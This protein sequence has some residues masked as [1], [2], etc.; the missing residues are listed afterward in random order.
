MPKK[1][2]AFFI[3][4]AVLAVSSFYLLGIT[5]D[6]NPQS[7]DLVNKPVPFLDLPLLEPGEQTRVT[8]EDLKGRCVMV[9]FFASWCRYCRQ[10]HPVLVRLADIPSVTLIGVNVDDDRDSVMAWL[11]KEGNPY[12][13]IGF[14][15]TDRVQ[16]DWKVSATPQTFLIDKK[17]VVLYQK[18]G[19]LSQKEVEE[20]I[21]TVF[22]S[23]LCQN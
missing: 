18:K 20:D 4:I 6:P 10:E 14:S 11:D 17:G 19:A 1:P 23:D 2:F 16:K 21:L 12:D 22:Q 3:G 5:K 13:L 15:Q 9:H 7:Q 8:N